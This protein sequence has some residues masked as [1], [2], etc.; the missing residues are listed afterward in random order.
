[1]ALFLAGRATEGRLIELVGKE[2]EGGVVAPCTVYSRPHQ[3]PGLSRF[4]TLFA[5]LLSGAVPAD[6]PTV[7]DIKKTIQAMAAAS[8]V[9]L[10]PSA[11]APPASAVESPGGGAGAGAEATP[12]ELQINYLR[13]YQDFRNAAVIRFAS[14]KVRAAFVMPGM[15]VMGYDGD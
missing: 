3:L 9:S 15:T 6:A 12:T 4:H 7:A 8:F 10:A 13:F 1:M 2:M 5:P 14:E 11:A